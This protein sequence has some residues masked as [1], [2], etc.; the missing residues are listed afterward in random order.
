MTHADLKSDKDNKLTDFCDLQACFA[1][2]RVHQN[3]VWKPLSKCKL[4]QNFRMT[5]ATSVANII[6]T[7]C[8]II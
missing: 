6:I 7:Y 1:V 5:F 3:T 2:E 8:V 4:D